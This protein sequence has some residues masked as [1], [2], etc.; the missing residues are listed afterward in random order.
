[1]R[2]CLVS[3]VGV[4]KSSYSSCTSKPG[5]PLIGVSVCCQTLPMTSPK[6]PCMWSVTG[7]DDAYRAR[8]MLPGFAIPV[9]LVGQRDLIHQAVPLLLGGQAHGPAGLRGLPVAEGLGLEL[10]H[11][12]RPVPGHGDLLHHAAQAPVALAVGHPEAGRLGPGVFAPAPALLGPPAGLTVAAGVHE[13]AVLAVAHQVLRRREG[14]DVGLEVAVLVVPAVE[15]VVAVLAQDDACRRARRA[16]RWR[17]LAAV[18]ADGPVLV[19]AHQVEGQLADEHRA[20]L[21]VDALVLDAHQ[22][23]PERRVPPDGQSSGISSITL[24]TTARTW[25]RYSQTSATGGQS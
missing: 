8:L 19:L 24:S 17:A 5:K 13:L 2:L 20:G 6:P 23:H 7:T 21:Q 1:M 18:G 11:L 25:R 3:K 12:H 4:E 16:A 22:D 10:V 14:R 9:G 15:G